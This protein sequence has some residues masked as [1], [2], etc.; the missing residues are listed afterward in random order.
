MVNRTTFS[1]S[2]KNFLIFFILF[3]A[4]G[5]NADECP[6]SLYVYK[7]NI[8]DVYDGDT[9]TANVDLGFNTWVHSESIV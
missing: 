7:A 9:V 5:A 1:F 2:Y 8:V 3:F 4:F 6:Q